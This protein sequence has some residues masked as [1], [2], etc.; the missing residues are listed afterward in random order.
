LKHNTTLK[1][2]YSGKTD[3][4]LVRTENQDNLGKFPV[5]ITDIYSP[6]GVLFI[7]ADGM[8]GHVGGKEASQFAVEIVSREYFSHGSINNAK[9]LIDAFNAAN[10]QIGKSAEEVPLYHKKGTTCTSLVL[11]NN[12]AFISHIGDSRVYRVRNS[13][14]TQ[15]TTDHTQV[16]EMVRKG[17]LSEE[18][19]ILYPSKSVLTQALGINESLKT[20]IKENITVLPDDIFILCTDGLSKVSPNEIKDIVLNSSGEE[21]CKKLIDLANERG[22]QDNVTVQVIQVCLSNAEDKLKKEKNFKSIL[23][24]Y[25]M[26]FLIILAFTAGYFIRYEIL[27][28]N[29]ESGKKESKKYGNLNSDNDDTLVHNGKIN[30]ENIL[31]QADVLLS[32]G[33]TDSALVLYDM[34]LKENPMHAEA[35]KGKINV[36]NHFYEKG[37]NYLKSENYADA[38]KF[39]EKVLAINPLNKEVENKL[40]YVRYKL[41]KEYEPDLHSYSENKIKND[42]SSVYSVI[43]I[44]NHNMNQASFDLSEWILGDMTEEDFVLNDTGIHFLNTNRSKQII[45][46]QPL[47]DIDIEV[48]VVLFKTEADNEAGIIVGYNNPAGGNTE[49]YLLLTAHINGSISLGKQ[50]NGKSELLLNIKQASNLSENELSF[51]IKV[52][53]L[54]PWI[55]IYN[56]NKLLDSFLN[57]EFIKGNFGL[58]AGKNTGAYFSNLKISSAF[59]NSA[60]K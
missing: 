32:D 44:E 20:E 1:I 14:I 45:N 8:G 38:M 55:M 56:N 39:F 30:F 29:S 7:V 13:Q 42:E 26:L 36:G 31:A 22:G 6:K 2:S 41:H 24:K 15:L 18:E 35:V 3:T 58:Y 49:N 25:Q 37:N 48:E 52:K 60:K 59:E 5:D 9:A 57:K 50:S 28:L 53:C 11:Q 10:K 54:G 46:K 27:S 4:G 40:D 12:M 33:N 21:A 16:S 43:S 47:E 17:I 19:A 34:I 23:K 51:R